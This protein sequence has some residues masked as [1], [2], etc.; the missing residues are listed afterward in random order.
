MHFGSLS[1]T[2]ERKRTI[3]VLLAYLISLPMYLLMSGL[4]SDATF[5]SY[6]LNDL[7]CF[8]REKSWIC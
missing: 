6:F 8:S 7:V 3:F 5:G 2:F 1:S 4:F